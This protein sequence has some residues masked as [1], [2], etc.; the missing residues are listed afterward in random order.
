[1]ILHG[2]EKNLSIAVYLG[3]IM[4]TATADA[5]KIIHTP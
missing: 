1:M 5:I 4:A 3:I 2:Y